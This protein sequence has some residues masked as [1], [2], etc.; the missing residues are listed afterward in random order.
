M[1]KN[2]TLSF[3]FY[4][5]KD[6]LNDKG[7]API[8]LRITVDGQRST[9]T[10]NRFIAETKWDAGAGKAKGNT[11]TIKEL[12]AYLESMKGSILAHQ[13]DLLD[14]DKAIT[15]ESLRNAFLGLNAK[16]RTLIEVFEYHN[17]QMLEKAG[18]DFA[19]A[20]VTRY[21]TTLEHV[22]KFMSTHYHKSDMPLKELEYQFVTDFEHYLKTKKKGKCNHNS[23]LKYIRNFRKIINISV[24]N[25]WLEKDPF[26]NFKS[27]LDESKR[28]YLT[29][30]ELKA[31]EEKEIS[32]ERIDSLRDIFVFAC[33]TGL[34]YSDVEKLTPADVS[35]GIDGEKWIFTHRTKTQSK[36]NMPLL[37]PAVAILN[38]YKNDSECIE[39]GRLLPVK[40]N[41][42]MNAYLK[43]LA[44][45]CKIK[46][47]LTFHT[48]R[49]TFATTVT[50]T[51]GVP[52]ES[53]SSMLGHKSICTTQ[54]YAK[55]VERKV[56]DDMAALKG[57]LFNSVNS[58]PL[59][60]STNG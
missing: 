56:S 21:D 37:P 13:R 16:Q 41:Q 14:H 17:K 29:A 39:T 38:K 20:T 2:Q 59:K 33:Y 1:V 25:N 43:E 18:K 8:H 44:N 49:H 6:A 28:T 22:K 52:I 58:T 30:E 45:I 50:L 40:S 31:I 9:V 57:K 55:V 5:R 12:N 32:I 36:S 54:I 48:A 10:T 23:T 27:K 35:T 24:A 47:L 19:L 3:L 53:V 34:A 7:Q 4:L 11:Q 46:K 15:A 60:V 42:K 51:N 26:L